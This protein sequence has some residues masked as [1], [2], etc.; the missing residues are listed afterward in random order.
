[1]DDDGPQSGW[2]IGNQWRDDDFAG[3][4]LFAAIFSIHN[5][6]AFVNVNSKPRHEGFLVCRCFRNGL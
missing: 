4:I 5:P 2:L 3:V 6:A 1:V